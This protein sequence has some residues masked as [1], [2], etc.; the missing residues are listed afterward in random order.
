M[1]T[2]LLVHD[3]QTSQCAAV[4]IL[5]AIQNTITKISFMR[6]EILQQIEGRIIM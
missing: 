1:F 3:K 4:A 2:M 6:S 5:L